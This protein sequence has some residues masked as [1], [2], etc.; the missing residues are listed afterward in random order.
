MSSTK[1]LTAIGL[2]SG[3][4][5]DGIDAAL[6]ETNGENEVRVIHALT[7]PY[8]DAF[9]SELHHVI[10]AKNYNK[11]VEKQLTQLHAQAVVQLITEAEY[12][13]KQVDVIGFHGQTIDHKPHEGITLQL[14]NGAL[15]AS[16][17][18]IDV[19]N[20]FRQADIANGGQG[21]PLVPIYHQAL[22][23]KLDKPVAI[24]NI[25]GVANITY[26]GQDNKL[27]AF[28]TGPG[29]AL[30]NDWCR[31]H[32][33]IPYDKDGL[34]AAKGTPD[35]ALVAQWLKDPYFYEVP[36]KSLDRNHFTAYVD[37]L[38]MSV[39][40]GAST[41][42]WFTVESIA[43]AQ[44]H[45]PESP[46]GWYVCGGG[47]HNTTLMQWL[48]EALGMVA[49]VEAL[50]WNGDFSEAEAFAYLAVRHL[51][52]LPLTFPETTGVSHAVVGGVFCPA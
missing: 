13:A 18:N 48:A 19:V 10:K 39:E 34:L 49:P 25:G 51:K 43:L 36:P 6:V 14:G 15:L 12:A 3:T 1:S 21:A 4:S 26:I 38:S 8:A 23:S 20:Q 50:C 24:V 46:I 30:I 42:T 31:K 52:K 5:L 16:L 33:N 2:M 37:R 28:D 45:M 7:L 35:K 41:L 11:A 22:T 32:A 44:E 40:D 17:T 9:A 29:S 47:R 27:I